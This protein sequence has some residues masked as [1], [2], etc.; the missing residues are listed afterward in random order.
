MIIPTKL[1]APKFLAIGA[2]LAFALGAGAGWTVRD[3]KSG[4][5]AL[6]TVEDANKET[7]RQQVQVETHATRYEQ[8]RSDATINDRAIEAGVR[9]IYRERL[10]PA[11][12]AVPDDARQLLADAVA[13]ANARASGQPGAG[14]P[15]AAK[16]ARAADR[17]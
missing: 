5:D 13:Q 7:D 15:G 6:E 11:D 3:W 17:P 2:A 9:T 16:P 1:L 14:L 12:C 4:H 8:E 10:V